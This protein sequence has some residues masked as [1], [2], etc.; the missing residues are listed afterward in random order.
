MGSCD[1]ND[2]FS[3]VG[4]KGVGES[5]FSTLLFIVVAEKFMP[6]MEHFG[7]NDNLAHYKETVNELKNVLETTAYFSD[8]YARAICDDGTVLGIKDSEECEIDILSQ[9]FAAIARLDEERTK[10]ALKLAFSK[11]YEPKTKVFRL[12]SPSFGN[13]KAKVGYIRG[14]VSGIR[15]NGGQYT[16]GALWGALGMIKCGLNEEALKIL[17]CANPCARCED[18]TLA[19]IYKA[20]PYVIAADV[21]SGEF[22]GRGGWSWYTGAAAWFYKIMLE[23]VLGLKFG[24]DQT[25]I[26][27]KPIIPYEAEIKLGN[28][29]LRITASRETEKPLINGQKSKFPLKLPNGAHTL[30]L[31]I[32]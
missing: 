22:L 8:R 26:S 2:A 5:V 27:A 1:W 9:A 18:K 3:L 31:P 25:I 7:D 21:Y 32:F 6:I 29:E 19:R 13:G 15:E 11:L 28:S 24:A 4:A 17:E 23:N 16:H 30:E 20:E 12:F 10:N 14:Y